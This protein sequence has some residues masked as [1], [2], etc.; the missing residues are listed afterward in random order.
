MRDREAGI[1][2][3]LPEG[4][5]VILTGEPAMN[6]DFNDAIYGPFPWLVAGVLVLTFAALAKAFRSWVVPLVAVLMSGLSLLATYGLLHL[7]FMEGI[8]AGLLGVDH[9]VRGIA[10]WVPVFIFAFLFGI[11]MDYQVFLTERIRELRE[12]GA[13]N[14]DAVRGGLRGTGR[15]I[16]TA[17]LIMV[18]AFGGFAAGS[19]MGMK[20]FGFGLAAAVAIDAL[21]VRCLIVPA[22]LA[23]AGER[24]W[25]TRREPVGA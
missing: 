12:G 15:I 8:G 16:V 14:G 10:N 25:R 22:I 1:T 5:E 13:R 4:G 11:S 3:A 19:D 6:N 2:D 9:D 21:L 20:E 23:M 7:V 18:V 17:A 24:S